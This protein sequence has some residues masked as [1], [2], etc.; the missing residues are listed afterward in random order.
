MA[1]ATAK[2]ML[3]SGGLSNDGFNT[4]LLDTADAIADVNT[5]NYV[6]DGVTKG[7]KQGDLVIVR[8]RASMPSGAISAMNLCWVSNVGTGTDA[9]G[10]DLTN[11]TAIDATD[12]D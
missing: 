11:G 9:Q 5:S 7:A 12:S 2:F 1:Y 3:H 4:W 10:I 6:S 8:T